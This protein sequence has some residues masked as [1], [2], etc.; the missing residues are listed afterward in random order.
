MVVSL[1]V[2]GL[3]AGLLVATMAQNPETRRF[4]QAIVTLLL[5]AV[6]GYFTGRAGKEERP[7]HQS[8]SAGSKSP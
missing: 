7:S 8:S 5:G 2:A 6:A 1:M 3:V 4:G